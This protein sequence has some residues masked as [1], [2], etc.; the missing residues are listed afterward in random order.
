MNG[1]GRYLLAQHLMDAGHTRD[2]AL[3]AV[4]RDEFDVL[5][6]AAS[7]AE[8]A[9]FDGPSDDYD[10][11]WMDGAAA[12]EERLVVEAERARLEAAAGGVSVPPE[13]PSITPE[14][15]A[16]AAAR[17]AERKEQLARAM[18]PRKP[19]LP[20]RPDGQPFVEDEYR[21]PLDGD[22]EPVQLAVHQVDD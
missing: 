4:A 21:Q 3:A 14:L 1:Y 12:V 13:S 9:M 2:Y 6:W 22:G 17:V 7:A 8:S 20:R 18:T 19:Q 10:Q 16:R 5:D 11:G 15:A